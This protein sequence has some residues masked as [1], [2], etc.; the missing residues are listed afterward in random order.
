MDTN[1]GWTPPPHWLWLAVTDWLLEKTDL[2]TEGEH[3]RTGCDWLLLTDYWKKLIWAALRVLKGGIDTQIGA[4]TTG[5]FRY[6]R[7][8]GALLVSLHVAE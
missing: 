1:R 4:V 8:G 2:P 6:A 3:P 7:K 5:S